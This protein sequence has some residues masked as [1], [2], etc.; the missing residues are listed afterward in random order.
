[1]SAKVDTKAIRPTY[2]KLNRQEQ[3]GTL[4]LHRVKTLKAYREALGIKDEVAKADPIPEPVESSPEP[5]AAPVEEVPVAD[6]PDKK[7]KT[8]AKKKTED[9]PKDVPEAAPKET[10]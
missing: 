7:P 5:D 6:K 4:P 8:P 10:K 3:E 1:M 2:K 9:I